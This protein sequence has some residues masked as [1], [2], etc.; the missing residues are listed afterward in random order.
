MTYSGKQ[1][2]IGE[3]LLYFLV[4]LLVLI[5]PVLN[6]EMVEGSR[7]LWV[8][9]LTAWRRLAPYLILFLLHNI[10]IAPKLLFKRKYV[11]YFVVD[12]ITIVLI[13]TVV[14]VY[15]RHLAEKLLSEG[16]AEKIIE[17]R[18]AS[19]TD[20]ALYWNVLL[21]FF[22]TGMNSSI[23]FMYQSISNDQKMEML[24]RQNLQA[25]MDSL[26]YQ[27]NPHFFMN[28]LNN[29]HAL[30]DIDTEV[31]KR[32]VIELSR[33]MRYVLYDSSS[34]GNVSLQKDIGFINNYIQLMRIRYEDVE[35]RFD[36]PQSV[37]PSIVI[38]PLLFIV[39][40]ENAFKHGIS[41]SRR[42]FIDMSIELVG[43]N[44]RFFIANS[45]HA[46]PLNHKRGIGL[47]NVQK[48][49]E[50]IYDKRFKMKIDST[51]KDVYSVELVIP[52][53]YD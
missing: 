35:I 31:A 26:R 18:Q 41:Y 28:T 24:K 14:D 50:L 40:V 12:I 5:V 2:A 46:E 52:M 21:G 53:S 22:M 48:R 10:V 3:N 29:I 27:I 17:Y 7:V 20:L 49:L 43:E 9:M 19:F 11:A 39:F 8:D 44:V 16:G 6:S 30:I 4:W 13:F 37:S 38:P 47:K 33:M 36:Y 15:E 45:R 23:K 25:E 32:S 51:S 34:V 1:I 42:S